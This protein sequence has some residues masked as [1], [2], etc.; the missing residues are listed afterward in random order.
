MVGRLL[1]DVEIPFCPLAVGDGC[2]SARSAARRAFS[3]SK[4]CHP[5]TAATAAK[6][7]AAAAVAWNSR[8]RTLRARA[9]RASSAAALA[10]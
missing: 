9:A 10:R 2:A 5:A 7:I 8:R 3:A 1:G 4:Y 6:T